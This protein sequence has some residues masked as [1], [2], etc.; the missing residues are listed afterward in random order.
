[1]N[2]IVSLYVLIAVL[3]TGSRAIAQEQD[4]NSPK[5]MPR[6]AGPSFEVATIKPNPSGV[7]GLMQGLTVTGRTVRT[8]NASILDLMGFALD[9]QA[10]QIVN[11]P[12][13][14][15]DERYDLEGVSDIEGNPSKQ[16]VESMLQKLLADRFGLKYHADKREMPAFV[17][18]T[19]KGGPKLTGTKVNGPSP[20]FSMHPDPAGLTVHVVNETL[21]DFADFLQMVVLDRPVVNNTGL[22]GRYDFDVTFTPDDSQFGGHAPRASR[23]PDSTTPADSAPNLFEAV[24]QQTGLR[25]SAERAAVRVIVVDH[26]EKPSPN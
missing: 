3:T 5:S 14:A 20:Q 25:L 8:R 1:M 10:K 22:T 19:G 26:V 12:S 24:Q 2:R 16:Q 4:R 23:Q 9:V 17:I 11:A 13:W 7:H 6:D 21:D 15:N 18:E